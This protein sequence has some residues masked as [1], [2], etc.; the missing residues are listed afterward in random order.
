M[1][2]LDEYKKHLIDF[3]KWEYDNN[4]VKRQEREKAL[5]KQYNDELLSKII[6]NTNDFVIDIF[7]SETIN[8]GYC[9]FELEEDTTSYISLKLGGGWPSDRLFTD[10]RGRLISVYLLHNIFGDQLMIEVIT[11]GYEFTEDDEIFGVDF[12]YSLYMQG[13]PKNID[14]IKKEVVGKS[15]QFI[16]GRNSNG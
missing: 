4:I 13:F 5:S 14:E 6:D 7:N 10:M 8:Y 11:E 3:Y 12:E 16:K 2:S 9:K 15:K 1:I